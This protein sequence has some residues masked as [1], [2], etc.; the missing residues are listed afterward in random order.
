MKTISVDPDQ[1][2]HCQKATETFQQTT[3]ANDFCQI[4]TLR[5]KTVLMSKHN[6]ILILFVPIDSHFISFP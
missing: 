6:I 2:A 5:V 4:S 1:T 3:K